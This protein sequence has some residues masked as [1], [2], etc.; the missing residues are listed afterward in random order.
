MQS[1]RPQKRGQERLLLTPPLD[2]ENVMAA[3]L[4]GMGWPRSK[5]SLG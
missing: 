3:D 5:F 4:V 1:V 2:V